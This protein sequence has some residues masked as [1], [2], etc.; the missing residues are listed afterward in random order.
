MPENNFCP[1]QYFIE[2]VMFQGLGHNR[3]KS[4][5]NKELIEK[6]EYDSMGITFNVNEVEDIT[7]ISMVKLNTQSRIFM[8]FHCI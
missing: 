5:H 3:I 4:Y 1:F 8:Q 7:G 6:S 2:H